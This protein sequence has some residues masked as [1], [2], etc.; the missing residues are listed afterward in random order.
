MNAIDLAARPSTPSTNL[1]RFWKQRVLAFPMAINFWPFLLF[2]S[3]KAF[4]PLGL[5]LAGLGD[6]RYRR[7]LVLTFY[8]SLVAGAVYLFQAWNSYRD[9]H[10]VGFLLF[11]WAIPIVNHAVRHHER[12]LLT[13]LTYLTI[14]NAVLGLY[15]Y[16]FGVSLEQ[17]RGLNRIETSDGFT[18]RIFFEAASLTAVFLLSTFRKPVVKLLALALIT[19]FV[20]F[21][22]RSFVLMLL[23]GL[24]LVWPHLL[25]SPLPVKIAVAGTGFALAFLTFTFIAELRP[26][27]YLS[28]F[29]KQYQ[30]EV[31]L[32]MQQGSWSAWG[33]GTF[34]PQLTSDI[35]QPYQIEM[36]LPMLWL[37][38]G[39]L[40]LLA[41]LGLTLTL[42]LS[43]AER[44]Y[45][46]VM[47]FAVY[48]IIGFNNPWLLLP[49]WFL[50]CQLL[51][52][53]GGGDPL[54]ERL[55]AETTAGTL[56]PR[57]PHR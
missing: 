38:L 54:S 28:I 11:V 35:E 39:P 49:S 32:S 52:R 34:I 16:F 55:P 22:T 12:D 40:W 31:I 47:R 27:V 4:V 48:A 26:D 14:F 37:Q 33:W 5:I 1:R 19:V 36:Q 8:L 41:V 57:A 25:R 18:T 30:L 21:V 46:G 51:F 53:E 9:V 13:G 17:F 10:V 45:L 23:L 56:A 50:T 3:Q 7:D 43:A 44:T 6:A 20:V 15:F 2:V 29:A 42:F 24:N